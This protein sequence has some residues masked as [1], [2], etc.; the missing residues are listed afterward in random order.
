MNAFMPRM[1]NEMLKD[2]TTDDV[3]DFLKKALDEK[4]KLQEL[5]DKLKDANVMYKMMFASHVSKFDFDETVSKIKQQAKDVG[6][7][8]PDDR[9]LQKMWSEGAGLTDMTRLTTI[10]FCSP[11]TAY[12]IVKEDGNAAMAVMMPMG[13]IVYEMDDGKTGVATYNMGM[14]AGMFPGLTGEVLKGA[15]ER[16]EKSLDGIIE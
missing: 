8:I 6:W 9:D 5:V 16:L 13:V 3:V 14:M 12:R 10:Y 2:V 7:N 1:M 11:S 4:E 15:A